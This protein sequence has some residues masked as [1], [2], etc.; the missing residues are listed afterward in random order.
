LGTFATVRAPEGQTYRCMTYGMAE[1]GS[2][3]QCDP[4]R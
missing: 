1:E 4:V 2:S 3:M